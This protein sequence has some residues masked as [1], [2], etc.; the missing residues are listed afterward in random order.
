MSFINRNLHR[1]CLTETLHQVADGLLDSDDFV[2]LKG[3]AAGK[4]VPF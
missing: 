1:R 4:G 3:I 2:G